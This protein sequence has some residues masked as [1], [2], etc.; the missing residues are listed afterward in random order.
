MG[1]L[2]YLERRCRINEEVLHDLRMLVAGFIPA[3]YPQLKRIGKAW[4]E[5]IDRLDE[6]FSCSEKD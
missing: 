2:E 3:T 5:A 6:E 4:D 1:R